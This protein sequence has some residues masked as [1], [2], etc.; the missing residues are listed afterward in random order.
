MR[1]AVLGKIRLDVRKRFFTQGMPGH[2][3]GLPWEVVTT[4]SLTEVFGQCSHA[5]HVSLGGGCPVQGQE[6]NFDDPCESL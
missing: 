3:N 5:H 4:P 6:L 1:E 2:W